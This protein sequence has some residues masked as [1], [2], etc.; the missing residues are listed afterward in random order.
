ML[1]RAALPLN[2]SATAC[3][4]VTLLLLAVLG[5]PVYVR[6]VC[7]RLAA[8][9]DAEWLMYARIS[10]V[11][12]ARMAMRY[13]VPHLRPLY[14]AQFLVCVPACILGEADLGAIG[15]GMGDPLVSW[16][17]L[18]KDLGTAAAVTSPGGY[19][20]MGLLLAVLLCFEVL[21]LED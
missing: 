15:F 5:W 17:T 16:G 6:G 18:L 2:L 19:L 1:L 10:G 21:S 13:I 20:P 8:M 12:T 14:L 11:S 4:G 3:A 7:A 9:R